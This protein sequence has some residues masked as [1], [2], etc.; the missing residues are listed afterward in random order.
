MILVKGIATIDESLLTGESKPV[1]K[2]P[3]QNATNKDLRLRF[4]TEKSH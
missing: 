2:S 1:L 3:I 4:D